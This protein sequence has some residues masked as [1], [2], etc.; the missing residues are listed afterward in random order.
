MLGFA[1]IVLLIVIIGLIFLFFSLN[2]G[3]TTV[4][5]ENVRVSNL[6]NGIMYY[7]TDCGDRNIYRLIIEC[8]QRQAEEMC[9][10]DVGAKVTA[11]K[12]ARDKIDEIL[13]SALIREDYVFTAK[14]TNTGNI[15]KKDD[16]DL[17]PIEKIEGGACPGKRVALTA[18]SSLPG[19]VQV[20]LVVCP[21]KA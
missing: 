15:F 6:L 11:C 21:L 20:K 1:F 13:E 14:Q 5:R 4:E 17:T 9:T 2:K 8:G 19:N 10:N 12:F 7:T 16:A 3:G 18:L